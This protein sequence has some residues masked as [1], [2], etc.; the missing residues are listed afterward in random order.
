MKDWTDKPQVNDIFTHP[1]Y[2]KVIIV[3]IDKDDIIFKILD[4]IKIMKLD[5]LNKLIEG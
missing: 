3:N 1:I 2:G 5:N 4:D